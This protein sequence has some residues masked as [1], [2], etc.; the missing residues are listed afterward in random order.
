MAS[1]TAP[2]VRTFK[3]DAAIGKGKF[4]KFGTDEDH[5]AICSA[6]T[7]KIIGVTLAAT[8]T[9]EDLVEVAVSGGAKV[10]AGETIAAGK[11]VVADANGDAVQSNADGD[12]A[13]GIAFDAAVDGDIFGIQIGPHFC[14]AADD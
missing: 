6:N 7:D 14:H 1:N 2:V 11:S 13:F 10:E 4:V 8:T 9:A 3:C 5:V 12:Y